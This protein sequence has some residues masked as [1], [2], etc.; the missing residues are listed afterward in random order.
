[1][2]TILLSI[3]ISIAAP[4][5]V[6]AQEANDSIDTF[7][8][9]TVNTQEIIQGR[10]ELTMQNITITASG[11]LKASAPQGILITGPFQVDPGGQ[12]ELNGGKQY[13]ISFFYNNI[14]SRTQ[15][16]KTY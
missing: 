15:R 12:L 16:R 11:Y 10:H 6:Q 13:Q 8:N 5:C 9:Q 2:K 4:I 3:I 7:N 1:M 14:G